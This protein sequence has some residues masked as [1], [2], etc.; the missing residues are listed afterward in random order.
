MVKNYFT[1][2]LRNLQKNKLFTSISIFGMAVSLAACFLIVLFVLDELQYDRHHIAGDRTFRIYNIRHSDDGVTNYLPIVPNTFAPYL[3]K[4]FPEIEATMRMMDT[5]GEVLFERDDKKL[6]EGGGVYADSAVFDMLSIKV[7]TGDATSALADVNSIALSQSLAKKYFGERDPVGETVTV[8]KMPLKVTAVFE[9]LP[10]RS[11]LKLSFIVSLTTLSQHWNAQRKENWIWQQFFT[12]IRLKPNATA[13]QLEA[14]LPAFIEKYASPK[15]KTE[16][17]TY[18]THLQNIKDIYLHSSNFEWEMAR[19]GNAQT[20]Y[21]L[22]GSAIFIL[23]IAC[24]NFINLSTARSIRRMKEVGVRK[25]AGARRRQLITQFISESVAITMIG[26]ALAIVITELSLP[27]LNEFTGKELSLPRNW[28]AL[29]LILLSSTFLGMVAGSYPAFHLSGFRPAAVLYNRTGMSGNTGS[30]RQVL[31]VIQFM[32]SFFLITGSMIVLTQNDLLRNKDLGFQREQLVSIELHSKTLARYET[33]KQEFSNHANVLSATVGFGLP[34]DIVAGDGVIDPRT[35]KSWPANLFLV[36]HD[37]I[38]TMNM[39]IV[40]G[41]DFSRDHATD[42][43]ES[44]IINE[45]AARAYGFGSAENA[46][47]QTLQWSEWSDDG[48]KRKGKVIG[49]VKDFHFK[50]LREQLTPVVMTIYPRAFWK[51][52]L[53]IKPDDIQATLAHFKSTYERLDPAWPFNYKFVDEN[54]NVMYK[55]EEKLSTLLTISTALAIVVSC[56]GLFGLVEY[57]VN[58][59]AKE[60]SIRKVFGASVN[61]LLLL[62]IRKYFALVMIAFVIIIPLNYYAAGAWLSN[63]AYHITID[64]WMYVQACGLILLITT[65]TVGFQSVKAAWANPSKTLRNE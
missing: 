32:F 4:D 12:Y 17:F 40:S 47:G 8:S 28:Q 7:V 29:V 51:I 48:S 42:S 3:Q 15:T 27:Y 38:Q 56:M 41:R 19:R 24:L 14:K 11:H 62:L 16:G 25:V 20:V 35:G 10:V 58:Q 59:R 49:V 39:K 46:V 50:S 63:F 22:S 34:G 13:E 44:F 57:S 52:T 37:Y 33:T 60:I 61:V 55:S 6:M 9:E 64:P 23:I 26:L 53:R 5:Y 31:V 45:T 1:I 65:A 36:D 43:T 54:F 21:A 2:A 18:E 30:F